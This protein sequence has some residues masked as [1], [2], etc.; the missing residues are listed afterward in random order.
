M[1]RLRPETLE[2]LE[3][4]AD[5][6]LDVAEALQR[7]GRSDRLVEQLR[8]SGTSAAANLFEADEAMSRKD[9]VKSL[10]IVNKELSE[11][12]FWLRLF[13]RQGWLKPDRLDPLIGETIELK[14][15]FGAMIIRTRTARSQPRP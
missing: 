5:R 3:H 6:V 2:R 7:Q 10:G 11:T 12:R 4:F 14:T 15:M 13:G 9:F 8:A 1:G